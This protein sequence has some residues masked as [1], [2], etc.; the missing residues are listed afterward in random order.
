MK[1][2]QRKYRIILVAHGRYSVQVK[3]KL[4]PFWVYL[5]DPVWIRPNLHRTI[6]G[7]E[8][9]ARDHD[10]A[11]KERRARGTV[12]KELDIPA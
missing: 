12:V 11:I 7:A 9:F 10:S 6:E 4:S 3:F 8:N 5:Y 1:L 2:L